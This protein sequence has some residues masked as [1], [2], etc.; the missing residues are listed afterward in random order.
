MVVRTVEVKKQASFRLSE[1]AIKDALRTLIEGYGYRP[2]M[3][4]VEQLQDVAGKLS[5]AAQK[6]PAWGWRYLRNV[7]NGKIDASVKLVNAIT[8][9]GATLDGIPL[10]WS[11]AKP[12][13]VYAAG[14]IKPG[15]LITKDS[16]DCPICGRPF[17]PNSWN[18]ANCSPEC[19]RTARQR[20]HPANG[21]VPA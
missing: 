18:D 1:N 7:L 3:I 2:D 6:E 21:K 16:R 20:K 11:T 17:I 8:S 15:T 13:Q 19:D 10:V 4:T 14:N 9:L 5:V 12:V